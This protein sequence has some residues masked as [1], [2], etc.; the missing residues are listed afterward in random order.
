MDNQ[1]LLVRRIRESIAAKQE[2]LENEKVLGQALQVA[3]LIVEAFEG[4]HKAIFFGNGGS[5]AD[6]THI[7]AELVGRFSLE[8]AP[9]PALSLTDNGSSISAIGN[10]YSYDE[11]FERQMRAF[12][13]PG[14]V[15][16][17]LT[18][19]GMSRNVIRGL[20]AAS[21]RG[22]SCVAFT[23]L[24]GGDCIDAASICIQIPSSSTA[25]I[26]ECYMLLLHS[27][28]E[29]IELSLFGNDD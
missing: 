23:G 6:A 11:V 15:A 13:E 9:L 26:Q 24:T 12:A 20:R 19:S 27:I 5:A 2:V 29:Q 22:A 17:A 16:V 10:D 21:E 4:G 28:C 25:R 18:T 14:D 7:A 8:R 1:S 3:S